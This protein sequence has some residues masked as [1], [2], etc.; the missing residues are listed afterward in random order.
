MKRQFGEK[1]HGPNTINEGSIPS[2]LVKAA[3]FLSL[4]LLI[5]LSFPFAEGQAQ[6]NIEP[7]PIIVKFKAT[8]AQYPGV[9]LRQD[10][11]LQPITGDNSLDSFNQ[12]FNV[13]S[14]KPLFRKTYVQDLRESQTVFLREMESVKDR[15]PKRSKRV[16]EDAKI[17]DVGN[18]YLLEVPQETDISAAINSLSKNPFVEYAELPQKVEFHWVPND[19]YWYSYGSW[20]YPYDDLWGL[21]KIQVNLAWDITRGNN[22]VV[23]VVDSGLDYYHPDFDIWGNYWFNE[24]ERNGN[25]A[26]CFDGQDDDLNGKI[27]DCF[28]WDFFN[29]D[30]DPMDDYGHGTH[31]TGIMAANEN[32]GIGVVGIAHMAKF[33]V[34]RA[35][36]YDI[37]QASAIN[38]AVSEGADI[39]NCSWGTPTFSQPLS[40]ALNYA[41]SQGV[42]VVAS[43]RNYFTEV[44]TQNLPASHAGAIT[45][46]ASTTDD[47]KANFS[48]FGKFVDLVAP[49]G[50][51]DNGNGDINPWENPADDARHNILSLRSAVTAYPSPW[52][53][54]GTNYYRMGGTSMSAPHVS[55][56]AALIISA[57]SNNLKLD[58]I[59][60]VLRVTSDDIAVYGKG[61]DDQTGFGRLNAYKAVTNRCL[62]PFVDVPPGYWAEAS[63][64]TITCREITSGCTSTSYCPGNNVTEAVASVFIIRAK[65]TGDF[66]YSGTP[67]FSDVLASHWAF[68]YI[69]KMYE[70][71]INTGCGGGKYCPD[72]L[73]DRAEAAA[74]IIRSIYGENFQ[75]T[76]YPPY[77]TDVPQ[78]HW[79]YKYIQKMKDK[80]ITAGCG[81]GKY[82]PDNITTREQ[83]AVFTAKAPFKIW[84]KGR[85]EPN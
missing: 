24:S 9:Y 12:T 23:A 81:G 46:G 71:G 36:G 70:D 52:L 59:Y 11:P 65:Y 73:V 16:P 42:A 85:P 75:Y 30:Y 63:I 78:S 25:D 3:L 74:Y 67:Y 82:C 1:D 79:A 17:P 7:G 34:L 21:K 31:V 19:P 83:M 56:V 28:G 84:T 68:K 15:F 49:G 76:T 37:I 14:A 33:M 66:N 77:F 54:V 69:Q 32:N 72:N 61:V 48:N 43:A 29:N 58:N 47:R 62:T 27:D 53:D 35:Y 10:A 18:V 26:N 41:Y 39:I 38:Y 80:G 22:V 51:N 55:G 8:S 13:I 50:N 40:D 6:E 20:G 45:V 5:L 44:T 64:R 57:E 2:A 4:S 60:D